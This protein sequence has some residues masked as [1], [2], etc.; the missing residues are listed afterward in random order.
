MDK[1]EIRDDSLLAAT[2]G[3]WKYETL[4]D[5]EKE[6]FNKVCAGLNHDYDYISYNEFIHEM[7]AKYGDRSRRIKAGVNDMMCS[8]F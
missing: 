1:K 6:R 4:T 5:E 8:G 7:N 3:R 2:G